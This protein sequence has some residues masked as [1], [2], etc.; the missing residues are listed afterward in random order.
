MN[1][2]FLAV[3]EN[4][5]REKGISRQVLLE[6]VE[7]ALVSAAKK[8]LHDKDKD[9][10][11]RILRNL[12][13]SPLKRP[14]R[15]FFKRSAKLSATWCSMNFTARWIPLPVAQCTVSKKDLFWSI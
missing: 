3:L 11:V 10:Q 7:A 8:V 2:E 6:S 14:S 5:E 9:V 1:A 12:G 15:L 4:I 13:V